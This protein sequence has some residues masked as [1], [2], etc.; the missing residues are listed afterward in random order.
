MTGTCVLILVLLL[1]P[2]MEWCC[3]VSCLC[4]SEDREENIGKKNKESSW[5]SGII[6]FRIAVLKIGRSKPLFS[7][8]FKALHPVQLGLMAGWPAGWLSVRRK[9]GKCVN[10]ETPL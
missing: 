9:A 1:S 10:F 4:I 6:I 3:E 2:C 5:S 8:I 7:V